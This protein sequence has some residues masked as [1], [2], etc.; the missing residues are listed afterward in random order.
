MH[1]CILLVTDIMGD[2]V[3][4][5]LLVCVLDRPFSVKICLV[6]KIIIMLKGGN[7]SESGMQCYCI[8]RMSAGGSKGLAIGTV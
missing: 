3:L 1:V 2:F 7:C 5:Y 6:G 4:F 8:H